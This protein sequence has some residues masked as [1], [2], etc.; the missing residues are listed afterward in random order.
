MKEFFLVG[1]PRS[2]TT[3]LQQLISNH[4]IVF[5]F[6]ESH[7]FDRGFGGANILFK[8][9]KRILGGYW[10]HY[11]IIQWRKK[12]PN[13]NN[14]I[15]LSKIYLNRGKV[16]KEFRLQMDYLT[17]KAGARIWLEKTPAHLRYIKIITKYMPNVKFIHIIRNGKDVIA[18]LNKLGESGL[19]QW[20][21]Y[22]N[23]ELCIERWNESINISNQY[24]KD[25][26][27]LMV[28][29]EKLLENCELELKRICKYIGIDYEQNIIDLKDTSN[30][31][32]ARHELPWKENNI[33]YNGIKKFNKYNKL[34]N[35]QQKEYIENRLDWNSYCNLLKYCK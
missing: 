16:V 33:K 20:S 10:L 7:F 26:S 30:F 22:A 35:K 25:G 14:E 4:S 5:S 13:I 3:L 18:S 32:I 17:Q 34:F 2:G 31:L 6:P 19:K 27:H 11:C 1:C 15:P 21:R 24:V 29:Y 28:S 9:I 23:I 8:I 12:I